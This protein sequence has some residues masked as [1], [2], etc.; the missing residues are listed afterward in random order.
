[1]RLVGGSSAV[2]SRFRLPI[3]VGPGS[4][5]LLI[6]AA[7]PLA[8]AVDLAGRDLEPSVEPPCADLG[9]LRRNP[10]FGRACRKD[11]SRIRSGR[12]DE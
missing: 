9:L 2:P 1:M 5:I 11:E 12:P 7:I 8:P 10:R 3:P 6:D 4:P